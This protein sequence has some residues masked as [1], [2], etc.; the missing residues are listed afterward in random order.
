MLC[1][2]RDSSSVPVTPPK[3][4]KEPQPSAAEIVFDRLVGEAMLLNL[5]WGTLR[6]RPL[7]STEQP[8]EK[9]VATR[10][11]Q[12]TSLFVWFQKRGEYY[13]G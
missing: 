11:D 9:D 6:S 2:G 5:L 13:F 8:R 3:E 1:M 10:P 4:C 7:R 12:K